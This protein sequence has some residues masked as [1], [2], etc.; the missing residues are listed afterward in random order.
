MSCLGAFSLITIYAS[1][2]IA[3]FLREWSVDSLFNIEMNVFD[4]K[5]N[6]IINLFRSPSKSCD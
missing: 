6:L 4:Q 5:K 3:K 1:P 2:L